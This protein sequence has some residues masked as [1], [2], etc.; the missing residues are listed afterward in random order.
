MEYLIE[1]YLTI[2]FLFGQGTNHLSLVSDIVKN[3]MIGVMFLRVLGWDKIFSNR[4]FYWTI[5][6][7]LGLIYVGGVILTGYLAVRFKVLE[8]ENTLSQSQNA[9]IQKLLRKVE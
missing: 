9:E 8:K 5:V 4:R 6:A 1:Q 3:M 2:K 7:F